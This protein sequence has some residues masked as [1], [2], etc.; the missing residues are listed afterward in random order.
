LIAASKAL[1]FLGAVAPFWFFATQLLQSVAGY[2][3]VRAGLAFLPVTLV[4]FAAAMAVPRQTRRS[5]TVAERV[6]GG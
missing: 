5:A 2:S 4:N 1:L 6:T 3:P